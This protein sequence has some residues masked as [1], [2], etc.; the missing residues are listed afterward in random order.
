MYRVTF[1]FTGIT[2]CFFTT[3]CNTMEGLGKDVKRGG[4]KLEKSAGKYT[5]KAPAENINKAS[6]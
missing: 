1:I 3:A 2:A 4:E 5:N 6:N